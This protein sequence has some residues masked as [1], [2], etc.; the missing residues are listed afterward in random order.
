MVLNYARERCPWGAFC[1]L[2]TRVHDLHVVLYATE[3]APRVHSASKIHPCGCDQALGTGDVGKCSSFQVLEICAAFDAFQTT[4]E[5]RS[6][7][8]IN[9]LAR[10]ISAS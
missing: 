1:L 5:L 8:L 2:P 3:L 6:G 10:M 7:V 9:G 4:L